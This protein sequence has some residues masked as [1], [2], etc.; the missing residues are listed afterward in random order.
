[1][2]LT[3]V[4]PP[5]C[6]TR[7]TEYIPEIIAFV[8]KLEHDGFAYALDGSV[9]FDTTAFQ[10]ANHHYGKLQPARHSGSAASADATAEGGH[11]GRRSPRD[12][13]LWKAA[14]DGRER[15]R[16]LAS[17]PSP[18]GYGR[19]GWHIE[20]SVMARFVFATVPAW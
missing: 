19:P 3:Q 8:Q 4:L 10:Q 14:A 13:A 16:L 12:F 20:C 17:W 1:V 6:I 18:W 5:A 11:A 7:V 15:W 2:S 9:Y